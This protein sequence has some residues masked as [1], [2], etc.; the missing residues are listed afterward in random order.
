[1]NANTII[2][3][4][5]IKKIMKT[6]ASILCIIFGLLLTTSISKAQPEKTDFEDYTGTWEYTS[7]EAPYAYQEGQFVIAQKDGDPSVHLIFS[8]GQEVEGENLRIEDQQL[9]FGIYVETE[10]V[11]IQLE[12]EEDKI[13]G[14]ANTTDSEIPL[15]AVRR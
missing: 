10:Y 8:N 1:M 13:T 9:K 11:S 3:S 7:P 6:L 5:G 2:Q 14:I 12:R 4:K 15:E